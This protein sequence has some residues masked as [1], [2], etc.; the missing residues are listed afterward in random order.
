MIRQAR[1]ED[2][3][4]ILNVWLLASLQAHDFVPAAYWWR[5]QEQM[6]ARYLPSAEVWVCEREGEVQ[7][8]IALAGDYLVALFVRPDCQKKG[9][10]KALMATAKRLRRQLTLKVFCENDIAVHFYRRHGFA[11]TEEH[12]DPGTGQPQLCMDYDSP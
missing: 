10:G 5:Q 12:L 2:T 8:F 9:I 1:P 3:E 11:I 7:G 4:A 6:R